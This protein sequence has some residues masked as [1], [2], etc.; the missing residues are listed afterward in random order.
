MTFFLTNDEDLASACA[1]VLFRTHRLIVIGM[2]V[3][4]SKKAEGEGDKVRPLTVM[5]RVQLKVRTHRLRPA[6]LP[7]GARQRYVGALA[8][9]G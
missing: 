4:A 3:I 2:I 8:M 1:G 9:D 6:A 7:E 5:K